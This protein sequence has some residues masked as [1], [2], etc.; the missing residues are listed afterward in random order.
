[1]KTAVGEKQSAQRRQSPSSN[2]SRNT[3]SRAL[4]RP[5]TSAHPQP[6]QSSTPHEHL[7]LSQHTPVR[8]WVSESH[9]I[10]PEHLNMPY[11]DSRGKD[12]VTDLK[13]NCIQFGCLNVCGL[14]QRLNYPEFVDFVNS[15]DVVC[16]SETHLD[17]FDIVIYRLNFSFKTQN[18]V[19]QEEIGWHWHICSR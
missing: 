5:Q 10:S 17:S 19:L 13:D 8:P 1:M 14:K 3:R 7:T 9:N 18:T 6:P 2:I 11:Q 4:S 12:L 16:V 15:F